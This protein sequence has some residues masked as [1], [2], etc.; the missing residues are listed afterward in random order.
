M[1]YR[2]LSYRYTQTIASP[3]T[4]VWASRMNITIRETH[5]RPATD[6]YETPSALIIKVEVPG[7]AEEEFEL[8]VYD[9]AL[10]IEGDRRLHLPGS[11]IQFHAVEI[12]YGHFRVDVPLTIPV[13][14]DRI[15]ATYDRGFLLVTLPKAEVP[16]S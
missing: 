1:R 4:D 10:V 13:Q 12:R 9:D 7:M 6:L 2:R 15:E 5:W 11:D 3:F 16:T 8:T 14:R